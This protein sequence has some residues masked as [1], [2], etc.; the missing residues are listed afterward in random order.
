MNV[1]SGGLRGL[2]WCAWQLPVTAL[3]R[4][5]LLQVLLQGLLQKVI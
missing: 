1:A 4:S 5:R 3:A 2:A